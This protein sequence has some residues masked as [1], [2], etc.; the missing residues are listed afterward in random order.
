MKQWQFVTAIAL[1][2]IAIVATM[3]AFSPT[4]RKVSVGGEVNPPF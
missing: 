3:S 1:I 4:N 2:M